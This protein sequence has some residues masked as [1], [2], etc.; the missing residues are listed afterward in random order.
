MQADL[1]RHLPQTLKNLSFH[2]ERFT[3]VYFC[4]KAVT[5]F[6]SAINQVNN[7]K[8][9]LNFAVRKK[10][11]GIFQKNISRSACASAKCN[12]GLPYWHHLLNPKLYNKQQRLGTACTFVQ[13]GLRLCCL[14]TL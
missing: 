3:C 1:S 4:L 5:I 12:N 7:T 6:F 13:D 9:V 2:K 14:H 11:L 8:S 10:V